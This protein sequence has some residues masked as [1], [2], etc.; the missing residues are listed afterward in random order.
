M[1]AFGLQINALKRVT[2]SAKQH[3]LRPF[4]CEISA[5]TCVFDAHFAHENALWSGETDSTDIT[6][7]I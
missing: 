4:K 3:T 1:T 5:N 2:I 7:G 6:A